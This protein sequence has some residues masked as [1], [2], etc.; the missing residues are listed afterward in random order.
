MIS[1]ISAPNTINLF[2]AEKMRKISYIRFVTKVFEYFP[3]FNFSLGYGLIA[4]YAADRFD[5]RAMNWVKGKPFGGEQFHLETER[6]NL[7]GDLI[8]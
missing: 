1:F 4:M 2:Y 5:A 3:V 7:K 8:L 6:I